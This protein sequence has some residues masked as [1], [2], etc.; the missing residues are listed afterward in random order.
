MPSFPLAPVSA[1]TA[2]HPCSGSLTSHGGDCSFL[3]G[4]PASAPAWAGL[5]RTAHLHREARS[6][7]PAQSTVLTATVGAVAVCREAGEGETHGVARESEILALNLTK[8]LR[9][10]GTLGKGTFLTCW[11]FLSIRWG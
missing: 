8:P 7:L 6:E 4:P 3:T 10:C 1:Q 2:A 5:T 9:S 11:Y